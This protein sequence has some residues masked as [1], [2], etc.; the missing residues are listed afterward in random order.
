MGW[1]RES[2][3]DAQFVRATLLAREHSIRTRR[4]LEILIRGSLKALGVMTGPTGG[5]PS[6]PALQSSA[7]IMNGGYFAGAAQC[8]RTQG[9]GF[10]LLGP[11]LSTPLDLLCSTNWSS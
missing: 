4:Q 11:R 8:T 5:K 10:E 3:L 6:W 1:F 2:A 9:I 7:T